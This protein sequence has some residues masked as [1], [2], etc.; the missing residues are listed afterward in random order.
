MSNTLITPACKQFLEAMKDRAEE[1]GDGVKKN[2][3]TKCLKRIHPDL[4]ATHLFLK[5]D[6][7]Q[8]IPKPEDAPAAGSDEEKELM[9]EVKDRYYTQWLDRLNQ[10][11]FD[12]KGTDTDTKPEEDDEGVDVMDLAHK[13][14]TEESAPVEITTDISTDKESVDT[15]EE[16]DEEDEEEEDEA[17]ED[18]IETICGTEAEAELLEALNKYV[19]SRTPQGSTDK[20]LNTR[21]AKLEARVKELKESIPQLVADAIKEKFA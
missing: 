1:H 2:F 10:G 21:I 7:W 16:D 14:K 11:Q 13:P 20:L 12:P 3:I 19:D 15:D 5:D 17:L 18:A 6:K 8:F 9:V 4:M